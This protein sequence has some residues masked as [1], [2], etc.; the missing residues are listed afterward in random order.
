MTS[1][2]SPG[3]HSLRG[4]FALAL[5]LLGTGS[6]SAAEGSDHDRAR[7]ALEA[8]EV[9]PLRTI[10]DRVEREYPGQVMEVDLERQGDR[11]IYE[12]KL[13]RTGGALVKLIVDGRDGRVLGT[14]T[15]AEAGGHHG[16]KEP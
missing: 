9:L 7:Q 5:A 6:L 13:L 3:W 15:R 16:R 8:G 4:A 1:E 14:R 11:W 10:L 2:R 12:I